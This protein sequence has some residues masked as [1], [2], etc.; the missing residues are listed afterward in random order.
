MADV[1]MPTWL[2]IARTRFNYIDTTGVSR[3]M[4]TGLAE[5]T[6]FGGDRWGASLTFS[7][8]GGRT[9]Q[10]R[11]ERAAIKSF[12]TRLKG[13]QNRAYLWDPGYTRR[14]SMPTGELLA[15]NTFANGST[16]YSTAG[17]TATITVVD[18]ALRVL[19][20]DSSATPRVSQTATVTTNVPYVAR[21]WIR[22]G[23]G[24]SQPV[25]QLFDTG[26]IAS[27]TATSDGLH[28]VVIVP[29]TTS[30]RVTVYG[31][32]SPPGMADDFFEVGYMSL[33]RCAL[34]DNAENVLL[35]SDEFSDAVWTKTRSSVTANAA[36]APDG[37]V[38]AD[39][40]IED[41]TASNTH[42]VLQNVI[43]SSSADDLCFSV[44]LQPG[45][46]TWAQLYLTEAGGATSV[47]CYFN[48][49]TGVVG[50]AN[51]GANWANLR[52]SVRSAGNGFYRCVILARKTNAATTITCGIRL[53]TGDGGASYT[54]NGTSFIVAWRA[55]FARSAVVARAVPTTSAA[56]TGS[57]QT[58][59][60]LY[61]KGWP[62][63]TSGLLLAD[64]QFEVITSRGSEL[65]IL[66]S[67]VN[68]DAAGLAYMQFEP[69]L[70]GI[71]ADN[72]PIIVHEPMGRF[73]FTGDTVGWDE[74][75]GV[76]VRASA[77]FEE[78]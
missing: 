50:T 72:A 31:S 43:V 53:A 69:P 75:P 60:A 21:A 14:G 34:A 58:G 70:R 54:G 62:A 36:T 76:I 66:T 37:T 65:K 74:S 45:T 30:G 20:T 52:T 19:L 12:L 63:S 23:K 1:L 3:A 24:S 16:G 26:S 40:I 29:A 7:P 78:V 22:N 18:R 44:A 13:K 27:N 46:R 71:P 49:S 6:G 42:E 32:A 15:N 35:R 10:G 56:I 17:G 8:A 68:S 28:T 11:M 57:V 67:P 73:M 2:K 33:S 61:T 38:T 48:L 77:E 59:S 64:D 51:T 39:S 47:S 9:A 41:S 55:S 4:Y 5:T 25:L